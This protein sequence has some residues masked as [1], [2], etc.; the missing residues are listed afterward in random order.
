M[1]LLITLLFTVALPVCAQ[2][3][4]A[5]FGSLQS[6]DH[7]L[8]EPGKFAP[9]PPADSI[10]A[11]IPQDIANS[12][13][14]FAENYIHQKWYSLPATTFAQFK[15][16]GNRTGYEQTCFEKRRQLAAL[17]MGEVMEGKGR[18]L[19][20][21]IDGMMSICEES[22][23]GLPAHYG[24]MTPRTEDQNVDLFN[25]ETAAMMAWSA[26]ILQPQ[27]DQYSPLIVK[28]IHSELQRR[29]LRPALQNNYWWKKAGMNWNPWICSNW[30]ACVLL[31][32]NDR[33]KQKTAVS[34]IM[35]CLDNFINAYPEDGGCDEGAG[36]WDRASGSLWEALYLLK[37]ATNG[38]INLKDDTKVQQMMAYIYKM[39]AGNGWYATFADTHSNR[40]LAQPDL[41]YP[42]AQY[43]DL[44]ELSSFAQDIA[45]K[46]RK[47]P[48]EVFQSSGN[49]PSVPRELILMAAHPENIKNGHTYSA[50]KEMW[51]KN[52]QI[53]SYRNDH[54]CV[55]VKGGNNGESHNHND[56]GEY[57]VM[58]DHEP[59][60]IDVG[61]GDY[62][63]KTFGKG[64]YDIWTMQSAYH[65]LPTIN[66]CMQHDGKDFA[67]SV[68]KH[69]KKRI[70][71]NL[72]G[73]YPKDAAVKSWFRTVGMGKN[74]IEV[75]E[76]YELE[77]CTVPIQWSMMTVQKPV[78]KEKTK[79]LDND[80]GYNN[81]SISIGNHQIIYNPSQLDVHIENISDKLDDTLRKMWGNK[82]YRIVMTV[83]DSK[84][85]STI[86][87]QIK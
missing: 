54:L 48:A 27:L 75:R 70:T 24:T 63:N 26:Y 82:M 44:P 43:F 51:L 47:N 81:E 65:N 32:E 68:V 56:V 36:Y 42:M 72:A 45:M 77:H 8:V 86:C 9:T 84:T 34:E 40:Y 13:I 55:F 83:K 11:F 46:W 10:R 33:D 1:R 64:R 21:I 3:H 16:N 25:A 76:Q 15:I 29:I 74:C 52:L 80:R 62:T 58:A 2:Q 18:F 23:W 78:K 61:T 41:V 39:Y 85:Q 53:A 22:W 30:L 35:N 59:L 7:S 20:D 60:L 73:A 19:P 79:G 57:I 6:L 50:P 12:Y 87:Y 38:T 17:V 5:S 4:L 69:D 66:G 28:R 49:W 67:V 31:A 14:A 71:L 37:R